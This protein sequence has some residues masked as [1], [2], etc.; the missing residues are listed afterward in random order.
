[1]AYIGKIKERLE[2]V[3]TVVG[4]YVFE[5]YFGYQ[6]TLSHIYTMKDKEGNVFVWKTS[7]NLVIETVT[8][9]NFIDMDFAKKGDKIRIKGTVK[10]HNEY[11]NE[12][13]T[14]LTRC[15][16]MEIIERA[17]TKEEKQELKKQEQLATLTDGDIVYN[18]KYSQYKK[19]YSDC[20]TLAGT[21]DSTDST[22]D[23]IVREGRL[24]ASGVRGKR[25]SDFLFR[26][27]NGAV[28]CIYAVS[29]E[30][31]WKRLEKE[32]KNTEGWKLEKEIPSGSYKGWY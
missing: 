29:F 21:Y 13:Q 5:N 24:K 26:H 12:P 4:D 19:H 9:E 7:N 1:M 2:L 28:R 6:P 31:A 11:R 18:M 16:V 15:K 3:V 30:N 10:D 14:I 8:E 20:E 23:V 25:F 17:L 27:E 32:Y 22:I